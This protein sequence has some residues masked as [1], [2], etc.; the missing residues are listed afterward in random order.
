MER[1]GIA[2]LTSMFWYSESDRKR[3]D[4]WRPEIHDSDGLSI[5]T[6][7][8][9]RLW[10]PLNNPQNVMTSTFSGKA[11]HGFGL[12]QR[13]RNFDHYQDD[14]VF[15]EKRASV[16]IEPKGDWGDGAVQLVEIPTDDEIHD[17]IAAYWLSAKPV[18]KGDAM[19]Y[20][21]RLTWAKDAPHPPEVG[22]V[23]ETRIGRGGIAGQARPR[24]VTKIVVDFDGG[25]VAALAR[26]AEGVKAMVSTSRGTVS[27]ASAYSVK[28]DTA[29]RAMFDL[30][31]EGLEP[32]EL[33][34]YLAQG[35]ETLT[36]T[37]A[38]QFLPLDPKAS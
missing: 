9:E 22:V 31:V 29:W 36:E 1:V 3:R 11:P 33:R 38:Y 18:A 34:L 4:D 6:G 13:D 37:W 23:T 16:W 17:N 12:L 25:K 5:W 35:E 19:A 24:G 26:E 21:Y 20:D 30:T 27:N 7:E 14:G 10:R 8:G 2:P 15:Y 32:V 28:V